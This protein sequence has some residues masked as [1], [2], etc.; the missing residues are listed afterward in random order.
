MSGSGGTIVWLASYPRSGNTWLRA[1]LTNLLDAS[2]RPVDINRLGVGQSAARRSLLEHYGDIETSELR[3][4]ETQNL[5]PVVYEAMAA[6]AADRLYLKIHDAYART[7]SGVPLVPA[8]VT[9]GALYV[10]RNPLDVVGSYASHFGCTL[11]EAVTTLNDENAWL[12]DDEGGIQHH[13]PQHLG[14]WSHHVRSWL[15]QP[16]IAV[17]VVR[18]EDLITAPVATCTDVA[19]FLDVPH[20]RASVDR[21]VELSRFE[22]L[23]RQ[24][25]S[26]GF[27]E[28][29]PRAPRFFRRGRAGE[30]RREL[31]HAQVRAI[32]D[33]HPQV[34]RRVGYEAER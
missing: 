21:A 14:S 30:W 25:A 15:D 3:P 8:S 33:A 23:Q 19:R 1:I 18:Y 24:E 2:S 6:S 31:S 7:P 5:R 10:V 16:A 26:A 34:M 17:H 27:V 13:V 28:R 32:V 4:D 29:S 12:A 20:T 22:E 11:D 9:H